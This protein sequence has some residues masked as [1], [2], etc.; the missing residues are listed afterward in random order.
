MNKVIL[1][2]NLC[3]DIEKR[4]TT[5]NKLVIQNVLAVKNDYKESD[6]SY[7]SQFINIT[8]WEH[9]AEYLSNYANK[10]SQ[11]LIEGRLTTRNYEKDNQVKYIT[12]VIV[13]NV[14]ILNTKKEDKQE[15]ANQEVDPFADMGKRV[16]LDDSELPW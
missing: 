6:G 10:G 3:R 7:K 1:L 4:Y 11:L 8:L 9:N 2:G 5:S 13:E 14:K 12:E 16:V 15:E